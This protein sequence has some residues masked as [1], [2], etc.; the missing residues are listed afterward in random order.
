[1]WLNEGDKTAKEER[2]M[3]ALKKGNRQIKCK[4][5]FKYFVK[6]RHAV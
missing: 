5:Q 6:C 4:T 1:M 3:V 2:L